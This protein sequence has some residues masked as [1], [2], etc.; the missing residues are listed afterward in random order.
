MRVNLPTSIKSSPRALYLLSSDEPLLVRDW[1][2]AARESLR[3]QAFDEILSHQVETGFDWEALFEEGQSLSLFSS[4]RCHIVTFSGNRPGPGGARFINQLV[5]NPPQDMVFIL[6]MAR[7]DQAAR[8]SAWCKKVLQHGE[9]VELKQVS[10]SQL[11]QWI[12]QRAATRGVQLDSQAAMYLA[13]LTEGNLLATDQELEKLA[14]SYAQGH[15]IDFAMIRD[16]ISRS[17]RYSQFLLTDACLAG[18]ARRAI[19]V[20]TGL[21][22]EGVQPI[23]IQYALQTM[24]QQL[25]QLKL[26]QQTNRLHAGIWRALKIWQSKQGLYQQAV[27][28]YQTAQLERM[29]QSCATLDRVNKGQALRYPQADWQTVY[30]L[31]SDLLGLTHFGLQNECNTE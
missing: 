27:A 10:A 19:K 25:L 3:A 9:L 11:P 16:S 23:P 17:A 2:D 28:R 4:R 7:L 26:A 1:L 30:T 29:I 20:L 6:V 21:R 8:N 24:L 18:D 12:Q 5:E 22:Q 13:D 31:V 14:L 15:L